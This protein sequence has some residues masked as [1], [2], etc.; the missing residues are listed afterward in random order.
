MQALS[1][2]EETEVVERAK[3]E[4]LKVCDDYV[5]GKFDSF[6]PLDRSHLMAC[7]LNGMTE[8]KRFISF[9]QLFER[10]D[11]LGRLGL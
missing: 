3:S 7:L 6:I 5:A 11:I 1:R 9:R 4:A 10:A 8:K 2:R